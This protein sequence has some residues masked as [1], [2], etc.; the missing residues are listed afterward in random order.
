VKRLQELCRPDEV[1]RV[2]LRRGFAAQAEQ[3]QREHELRGDVAAF[4]KQIFDQGLA[5][6]EIAARLDLVPRTVRQ[7]FA[8]FEAARHAPNFA[9]HIMPLGRPVIRSPRIERSAVLAVLDEVGPAIGVPT[10]HECFPF[11]ARAELA[12]LLMRYRRWWRRRNMHAPH[13]LDWR[14]SGSVW[15]MDFSQ[16]PCR[17][18]GRHRHLLAVR[19]LASGK[20]LHWAPVESPDAGAA[21]A[22]LRSLFAEHGAPLV[23]KTDNGS[24]F[25]AA[26]TREFLEQ[27]G[28]ANLFSPAHTP[29]YNGAIEAGIGSLKTRTELFAQARGRPSCWCADDLAAAV[30]EADCHARPRGNYGP[31]P[32]ELWN[33]RMSIGPLQRSFFCAVAEEHAVQAG[34]ETGLPD[35]LT[36]AQERLIQRHAVRRALVELGYLSLSRRRLPLTIH[37]PKTA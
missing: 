2:P 6:P 31:S 21:I 17:I 9:P 14:V 25:G 20:T 10:L 4:A 24:P 35:D 13:V 8:E 5:L 26:S 16:A 27:S 36:L 32:H 12:D 29:R 28:V 7:W 33:D 23:L 18:D 1:D 15:A 3:R 30:L 19:D 34:R 37:S 22:A 11:M